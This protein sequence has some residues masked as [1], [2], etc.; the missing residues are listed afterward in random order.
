M[1]ITEIDISS[2]STFSIRDFWLTVH[3][4]DFYFYQDNILLKY[5]FWHLLGYYDA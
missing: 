2:F 5:E 1:I 3:R 4:G